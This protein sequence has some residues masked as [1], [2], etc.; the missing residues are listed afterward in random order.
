MH[1][2]I[3]TYIMLNFV[4]KTLQFKVLK[5]EETISDINNLLV[6]DFSRGN[7]ILKYFF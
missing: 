6:P 1:N 7:L 4:I 5:N 2:L 3:K